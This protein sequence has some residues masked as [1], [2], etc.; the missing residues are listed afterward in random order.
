MV[1]ESE[2]QSLSSR[3]GSA[4]SASFFA[5]SLDAEKNK[6]LP[7][8]RAKIAVIGAGWWS[9]GWHIPHLHRNEK[10][11]LVGI[12]DTSP[13]P[14]SNLNPDLESLDDLA[15]RYDTPVYTSVD[16]LLSATPD[17][18]GVIVATPHATHHSVG[19]KLLNKT[20]KPLH[21]LM[22]KPMTTNVHEAFELHQLASSP[23]RASSD[24]TFAFLVN[25]SAN[26]RAQTVAARTAVAKVGRVRH[27]SLFFASALCWIF[28]R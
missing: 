19:L 1:P 5:S 22:E 8:P 23:S 28:V 14:T 2:V 18:D 11:D 9:Q 16:E 15:K 12:V 13:H 6:N 26:Y 27:V 24:G 3:R 21:I 20:G 25:H 7:P 4:K 10:V 17:L